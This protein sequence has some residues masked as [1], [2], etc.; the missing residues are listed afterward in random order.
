MKNSSKMSSRPHMHG[1][2]SAQAY[3]HQEKER[4]IKRRK[5]TYNNLS[6]EDLIRI[7]DHFLEIN[8]FVCFTS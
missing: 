8:L 4:R 1:Q 7:H 2:A 5:L 6:F 3:T